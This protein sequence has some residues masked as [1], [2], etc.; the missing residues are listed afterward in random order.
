LPAPTE[1]RQ[2]RRLAR[3][4]QARVRPRQ[5]LRL[6]H[7]PRQRGPLEQRGRSHEPE[8]SR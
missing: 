3:L 7:D 8:R 1:R 4:P 5:A 2:V 6:R